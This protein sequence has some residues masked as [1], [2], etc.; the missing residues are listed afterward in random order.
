MRATHRHQASWTQHSSGPRAARHNLLR[1]TCRASCSSCCYQQSGGLA[2]SQA[3]EAPAGQDPSVATLPLM[4]PSRVVSQCGR[5]AHAGDHQPSR[6]QVLSARLEN[7]CCPL[8][9]SLVHPQPPAASPAAL[10]PHAP[11]AWLLQARSAALP[12]L[13]FRPESARTRKRTCKEFLQCLTRSSTS[14]GR[15]GLRSGA[16][17]KSSPRFQGTQNKP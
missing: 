2:D 7:P 5:S 14:S 9:M 11:A 17:C 4:L 8:A 6:W 10:P 15:F 3:A 12:M 13:L 1:H 16:A